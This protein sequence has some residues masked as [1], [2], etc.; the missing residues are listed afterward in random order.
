MDGNV[1]HKKSF[2]KKYPQLNAK[3]IA[4]LLVALL[5]DR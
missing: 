1:F 5:F 3:K 2:L 4:G